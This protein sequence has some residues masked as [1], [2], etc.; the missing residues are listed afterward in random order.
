VARDGD[1][2]YAA[3]WHY[4]HTLRLDENA[5]RREVVL[6]A[7]DGSAHE[8]IE[9]PDAERIAQTVRARIGFT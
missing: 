3:A 7:T 5:E 9:G 6:E 1:G 8:V 2:G 4:S